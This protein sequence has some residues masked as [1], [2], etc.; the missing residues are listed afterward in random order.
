MKKMI[1]LVVFVAVLC[2][3]C[4]HNVGMIG[5]GTGFRVG[6]GEYGLSYGDGLFGTFVARDGIT[7]KAELDSTEG[8]SYDPSSNTYKG[9]KSVE[10][11]VSPQINGYAVDFAKDNPEVAKAYY[12][13]LGKYYESQ[14]QTAPAAKTLISDEKSKAATASVTT[15]LAKAIAAAR[16]VVFGKEKTDG[17]DSVFTCD[18]DC[19]YKDLAGNADIAYQ[20]S[21]ATKLLE[22]D[23]DKGRFAD[24]GESYKTT[25]EHFISELLFYKGGGHKNTP[26]RVKCVT[27]KGK[28]ITDLLYVYVKRDGTSNDITCPSCVFMS[29]E[30]AD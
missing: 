17:K 9:I 7:F 21:I 29:D 3:S 5:V 25:L 10:Y 30:D 12:E 1:W 15:V 14:R 8:F 16:S 23:G 22:Y 6:G 24:T 26:L 27:V 4:G 11:S 19:E 20:L 28:V 2:A 18:G 13:A